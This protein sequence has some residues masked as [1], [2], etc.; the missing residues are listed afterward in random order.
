MIDEEVARIKAFLQQESDS[1]FEVETKK[2]QLVINDIISKL[3]LELQ[4]QK[5]TYEKKLMDMT[6]EL[7]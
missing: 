4:T 2:H 7:S 6:Q 1:R 5:E 3:G